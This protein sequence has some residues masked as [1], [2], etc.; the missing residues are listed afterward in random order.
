MRP[1]SRWTCLKG[2]FGAIEDGTLLFDHR[3]E[4]TDPAYFV[5]VWKNDSSGNAFEVVRL[6]DCCNGREGADESQ[7]RK[8]K[9]VAHSMESV[10]QLAS[11]GASAIGTRAIA[12]FGIS[13]A[14]L[15][16]VCHA[17]GSSRR[18]SIHPAVASRKTMC[19]KSLESAL[20][21]SQLCPLD[22]SNRIETLLDLW[23]EFMDENGKD[24]RTSQW[25]MSRL[26]PRIMETA[27]D[28]VERSPK[29][30]NDDTYCSYLVARQD[31]LPRM[32]EILQSTLH[33][34]LVDRM[35]A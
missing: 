4:T 32:E 13:S 11:S 9:I 34:H 23:E 33:N 18:G 24:D 31:T 20:V 22:E 12:T 6:V 16:G 14:V 19:S 27:L 2:D 28:I 21:L 35:G 3:V 25:K 30:R 15:F 10:I 5:S 29:T 17:I 8:K 26:I 1:T 7:T